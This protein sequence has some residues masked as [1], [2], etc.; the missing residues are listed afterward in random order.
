[1]LVELKVPVVGESITEVEIFRWLRKEG[2]PVKRDET[3]VELETAKVTVELPSPVSGVMGKIIKQKGEKAN[4]GEIIA[5]IQENGSAAAPAAVPAAVKLAEPPKAVSAPA[6]AK[7]AVAAPVAKVA[8]SGPR[9]EEV[10]PMSPLRREVANRLVSA[11]HTAALLTTFNEIDM[12][13]VADLRGKYKDIFQ[14]R[15]GVKLG[16]TSFFVK[17]VVDALK[18]YPVLNAEVRDS[19]VAYRHY[20]DIGVAVDTPKGLAVPVLRNAERMSFADIERAIVDF[21]ARARENKLRMD[22]LTGGTFTITNGGVFGSMLSTPIINPPQ[23]GILG[24]HAIQERP[25]A[26]NGQIVI[27]PIMYAALTYDHRIVDGRGAV[28]FLK[29]VKEVIEEPALM[30]IE[31]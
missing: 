14:Q 4:V 26:R 22:E 10:V 20:Y 13:A 11:Q 21:G 25:V 12:S 24:L 3:L 29:R 28:G 15:Y 19:S 18:H 16:M 7:P 9:G 8:I 1:M 23:S 5:Y 27:R 17:A 31:V 2:D 30:L 6:L